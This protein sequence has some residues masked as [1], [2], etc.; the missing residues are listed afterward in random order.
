MVE[1]FRFMI[2]VVFHT[3]ES[4]SISIWSVSLTTY[5]FTY[6]LHICPSRLFLCG[7]YL[8]CISGFVLFTFTMCVIGSHKMII[9]CIGNTHSPD[10]STLE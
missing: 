9:V 2:L 10:D 6:A 5:N 8:I 1:M 7:P 4:D 3:R